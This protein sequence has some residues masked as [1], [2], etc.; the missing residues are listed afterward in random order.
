MEVDRVVVVERVHCD[1]RQ[2]AEP[3]HDPDVVG[4]VRGTG[5]ERAAAVVAQS[6]HRRDDHDGG[7]LETAVP[8]RD[9]RELLE[10][11]VGAE[12]A[13][14]DDEVG[15]RETEAIADERARPEGDVRE[16]TAVHE[17]RA[18]LE[19]LNEVRLQRVLQE[20]GH[21]TGRVE[22]VGCHRPPV[23]RLRRR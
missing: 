11:H 10:A 12:A 18:S 8:A 23:V 7:R 17:R 13:L 15:E 16:R 21:R 6:L 5:V 19:R 1:D 4:E 20:H 2:P 14:G 3:A 22:V 9:V